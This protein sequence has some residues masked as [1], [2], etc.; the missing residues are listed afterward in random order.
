MAEP[1][2]PRKLAWLALF[3]AA[4]AGV[5]AI[6]FGWNPGPPDQ[7]PPAVL[8]QGKALYGEYC[9][10]C[11]GADLKGQPEWQ[12]PL[13]SG[14]LPAPP[15]DASGHT[16]HH[17]DQVLVDIVR[18]GP[19]AFVGDGYESDMPGFDGIL[20]DDRIRAILAYLKSA[21]PER[22]RTFQEE[23]TREWRPRD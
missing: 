8:A 9:A 13:P 6:G 19:A 20:D 14:R 11:H 23:R 12:T 15:H 18:Q 21:W 4:A 7:A 5:L 17:P 22:E 1:K 10:A 2:S 16:W 3:A